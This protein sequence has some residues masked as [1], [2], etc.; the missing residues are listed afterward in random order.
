MNEYS[1]N[2][3]HKYFAK[4]Q[5]VDYHTTHVECKHTCYNCMTEFE[6]KRAYDYHYENVDCKK[7]FR[8]KQC[9]TDFKTPKLLRSHMKL[10]DQEKKQENKQ[11]HIINNNYNC[12]IGNIGNNN[13]NIQKPR[14]KRNPEFMNSN[15]DNFC[16]IGYDL[17]HISK[18][19][20][21]QYRMMNTYHTDDYL[22]YYFNNDNYKEVMKNHDPSTAKEIIF[23]L[24]KEKLKIEGFRLFFREIMKLEKNRNARIRKQK[25]G[26]IYIY[27]D[28]WVKRKLSKVI[29][30]ICR[31]IHRDLYESMDDLAQF[32]GMIIR[33]Q[34]KRYSDMRKAIEQEIIKLNN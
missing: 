15:P 6:N 25:S 34:K 8:C 18:K 10:H 27:D 28:K 7:V 3:C 4:Q 24:E 5:N 11:I 33:S 19:Q 31:K 32:I 21:Q 30:Q 16:R 13:I 17:S 1:C 23:A 9:N 14:K 22:E 26:E 29:D 20:M 2:T 12:N